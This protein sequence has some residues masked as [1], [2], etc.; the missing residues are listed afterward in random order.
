MTN[1]LG[2]LSLLP[3][4][5]EER[6]KPPMKELLQLAP[7]PEPESSPNAIADWFKKLPPKNKAAVAIGAIALVWYGWGEMTAPPIPIAMEQPAT[8]T[9]Q[10]TE[11][12]TKPE[13]VNVD[14]PAYQILQESVFDAEIGLVDSVGLE[15][16][17][18]TLSMANDFIFKLKAQQSKTPQASLGDLINGSIANRVASLQKASGDQYLKLLQE[19][20][21][22]QLADAMAVM[23]DNRT[24][25]QQYL[26]EAYAPKAINLNGIDLKLSPQD[27]ALKVNYLSQQKQFLNQTSPNG[28][29]MEELANEQSNQQN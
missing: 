21:A 23:A 3:D 15:Q 18:I 7:A 5:E 29:A 16:E 4:V 2:N 22:L 12:E 25:S 26:I 11:E 19:I 20:K 10:V 27:V 28:I 13:A 14:A 17:K 24:R 8:T 1:P 6:S 9:E